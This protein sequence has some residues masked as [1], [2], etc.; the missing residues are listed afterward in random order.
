M[1]ATKQK[2]AAEKLWAELRE[3]FANAEAIIKQII[4]TKAW[5]PLGYPTFAAAWNDRLAGLR[6]A[7]DC[8]RAHV[9]YALFDSGLG[10]EDVVKATGGQI[11]DRAA[12]ALAR[13]KTNGVPPNLAT[14]RVRAHERVLPAPPSVLHVSLTPDELASFKGIAESRGLD[15]QAE[16]VKALRAHFRNLERVGRAKA[17][18]Q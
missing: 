1:T 6:L 8:M 12:A 5:E 10:V 14:T 7:T 16:A 3:A 4:E 2:A 13:Q 15:V 17:G 11:G 18:A 9:A